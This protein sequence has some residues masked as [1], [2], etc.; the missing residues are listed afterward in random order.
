MLRPVEMRQLSI[1]VPKAQLHDLLSYAGQD[2]SLHLVDIP[3]DKLP[4]G[5]SGYEAAGLLSDASSLRNRLAGLTS[6]IA[7]SSSSSEKLD[8]PLGRLEELAS[9]LDKEA[10]AIEQTVRQ[11]EDAQGKLVAEQERLQEISR[12]LTGLEQ[13]GVTI[14][15]AEGGFAAILAGE[16]PRENLQAVKAGANIALS[17]RF[18]M[19]A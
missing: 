18:A 17:E 8:A 3:K 11:H 7:Y 5:A 19:V 6:A 1:I 16:A 13:V 12:F 10:S 4:E 15:T 2:R 9:Y 14:D